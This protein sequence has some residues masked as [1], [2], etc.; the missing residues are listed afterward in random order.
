MSKKDI[1]DG[2]MR[3]VTGCDAGS[4][5]TKAEQALAE[6]LDPHEVVDRGFIPGILEVE[7]RFSIGEVPLT[8]V[9]EAAAAMR[10]GIS[11]LMPDAPP[12]GTVL[13]CTIEG[14]LHSFGKDICIMMLENLGLRVV[15]LGRD[16]PVDAIIEACRRLRPVIVATSCSMV[17]T[18][19]GQ[20]TLERRL[21]EEGLREGVLTCVGG[22]PTN[23]EWA[24][25]I[26][27]DI[28]SRDAYDLSRRIWAVLEDGNWIDH[29]HAATAR[30][31]EASRQD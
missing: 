24:S 30:H 2:A 13:I 12:R 3:S 6:G 20:R 14:D 10:A 8:R 19:E 22:P 16:V 31:R 15:D 26:G 21:T 28:W 11:I 5:R 27:A 25:E 1:I 18:R 4:A 17:A 9:S 29:P 23:E 7:R